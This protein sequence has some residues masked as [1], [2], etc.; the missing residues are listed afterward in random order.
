[1]E[2]VDAPAGIGGLV[3][4]PVEGSLP[5]FGAGGGPAFGE[6]ELG[7]VVAVLLDEGEVLGA[8][9]EAGGEGEGLEVGVVAGGLVVEGEGGDV[10]G[11]G[12]DAD[13]D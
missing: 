1:M 10:G 7:A 4:V 6:P 9:D 5:A 13:L 3:A 8:G 2:G 11:V 12:G